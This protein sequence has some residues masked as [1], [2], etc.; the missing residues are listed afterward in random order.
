MDDYEPEESYD[1]DSGSE[2]NFSGNDED[3]GSEHEEL[4]AKLDAYLQDPKDS[5]DLSGMG[6]GAEGAKTIATLLPN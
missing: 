1:E 6:I 4:D 2:D 5:L 3:T